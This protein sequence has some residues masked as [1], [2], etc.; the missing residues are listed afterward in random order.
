MSLERIVL[1]DEFFSTRASRVLTRMKIAWPGE[2][3]ELRHKSDS[4][5]LRIDGLGPVTLAELRAMWLLIR[6]V[7][8]LRLARDDPQYARA[9][10]RAWDGESID[11]LEMQPGLVGP[12]RA[13]AA[14]QAFDELEARQLRR[15][16]S[17]Q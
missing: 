7:H 10:V 17:P 3:Q 12:T 13:A 11:L 5:L 6:D 8:A 15:N 16:E 2:F 14:R 4:E 1:W 9:W